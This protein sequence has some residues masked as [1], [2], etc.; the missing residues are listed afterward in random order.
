MAP[1]VD[2]LTGGCL[3]E[4]IR[5]TITFSD[6]FQFPPLV[7]CKTHIRFA[8]E[9]ATKPQTCKSQSCQC[10]MCRK[11]NASLISQFLAIPCDKVL[12]QIQAFAEYTEYESSPRRFRG[13]CGKCGSSLIWRSDDDTKTLDLF[14]GNLDEK[15]LTCLKE[16]VQDGAEEIAKAMGTVSGTQYWME[17]RIKLPQSE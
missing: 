8:I 12:P 6:D 11:W 7:S 17:V 10:T 2:A 5:Y 4:A 9:F 3:C 14:L 15:W 13:F 16:G 1:E